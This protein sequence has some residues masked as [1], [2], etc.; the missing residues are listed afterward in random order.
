MD[1]G[2][3]TFHENPYSWNMNANVLYLEQPAGVGLSYC[4]EVEHP[5]D[6]ASNDFAGSYDN[7][8]AV[9]QFFDRFPDFKSNPLYLSGE[10]YA[11][12]YIPYLLWQIDE[13]N[14]SPD[15]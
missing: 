5:E 11:G 4:D 14:A 1:D 3:T 15:T 12:I 13:F 6:C 9:R 10:S 2:D 8:I 7:V